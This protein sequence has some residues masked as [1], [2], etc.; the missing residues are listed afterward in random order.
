[1]E[2]IIGR[3]ENWKFRTA[4]EWAL[5][6]EGFPYEA[7]SAIGVLADMYDD[8]GWQYGLAFEPVDR[9]LTFIAKLL[10][11]RISGVS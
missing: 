9:L 6:Y 8:C 1:M 4:Y 11:Y 10:N 3:L 7:L 5:E 2:K